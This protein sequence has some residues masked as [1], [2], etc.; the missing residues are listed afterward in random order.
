MQVRR[1]Q[2]LCFNC[3]EKF[4]PDHRCKGRSTLLYLEDVEEDS[5]DSD[6]QNPVLIEPESTEP[7]I[8]LNAL[9]GRYG[10]KSMR[11]VGHIQSQPVQVLIDGGSTN[12]FISRQAAQF[13]NLTFAPTQLFRVRVGNGEAL[14]CTAYCQAV[15]LYIQS[16]LFTTYLFI[17]DLEGSDVVLGVQ[18]LETLGPILTDW[19]QLTM[20]FTYNGNN[21]HLQ[22]DSSLLAQAISPATLH[23][24]IAAGG[25]GSSYMCL[26]T[27]PSEQNTKIPNFTTLPPKLQTTLSTFSDLFAD[28]QGLPPSRPS[29]H[30]I[31]LKSGTDAVNVKP[32]RY[33]HFQKSEIEKLVAN[34]LQSGAIRPSCS[35]F[36]SPVLLMNKKDGT[37]RFCV[38]YRALNAVTI[39][40]RFPIPTVDVLNGA[41]IF[42]KLDLRSGYHQIRVHE[43][44]I[45]KIAFRT[46]HGH[47]ELWVMSFGLSNAP[48]T[49]QALMNEVFRPLLRK[50]VVIFFDD[51]L[52]YS[53]SLEAHLEH[54]TKVLQILRSN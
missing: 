38:D 50:F 39:R 40:D 8:S 4:T 7:E 33:P 36:S 54:L 24:L 52:V 28:P 1:Q 34:L 43:A 29:D 42:L 31:S 51:I 46:H 17:L 53:D 19:S 27:E 10:A 49:F 23:K 3:D 2:G 37:W 14:Q 45:H 15:S 32:Y 11:M 44:D 22:G 26:A 6:N 12:N 48:S 35:T 41:T 13:L 30:R 21:I 25:I 20:E 9:L 18:W 16:H 47:F 5:G